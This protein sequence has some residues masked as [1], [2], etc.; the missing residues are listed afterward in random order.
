MRG[1]GF[2]DAELEGLTEFFLAI[3]DEAAAEEARRGRSAG[4]RVSAVG[5]LERRGRSVVRKGG[6]DGESGVKG[7]SDGRSGRRRSISVTRYPYSNSEVRVCAF[8]AYYVQFAT[9]F[10]YTLL[11]L[12]LLEVFL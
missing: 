6:S 1:S 2:S 8:L 12:C 9:F 4:R 7:V 10:C 5:G 11:K 3:G